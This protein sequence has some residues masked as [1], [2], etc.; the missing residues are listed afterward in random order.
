MST[1]NLKRIGAKLGRAARDLIGRDDVT[2]YSLRHTHA[3]ALHYAGFTVPAAARRLGHGPALHV[4]T[5]AHVIDALDGQP[6]YADL[7]A[8]IAAA[9][10]DVPR[11][12]PKLT[13][14]GLRLA[15]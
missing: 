1:Y 2:L 8:L 11:A 5:Y 3:S 9:R 15:L 10:A 6:H 4:T 7:D 13:G 12:F 14:N